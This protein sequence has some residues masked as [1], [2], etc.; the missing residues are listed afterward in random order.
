[1]GRGLATDGTIARN[2]INPNVELAQQIAEFY[3]NPLDHVLF[4]YPWNRGSLAGFHGPDDWARGYLVELGQEVKERAFDGHNAVRPIRFSTASGHGIGKSALVAWLIRWLMDTRPV[5]KGVVTANT[6]AQLRSKTWAEL[7]KWHTLGI[8][9]HWYTLTGGTLGSLSYY[10]TADPQTWRFDAQTCEERN[11]EAFAGQHAAGSTSAYIFDEAGGI[12]DKIFEVREGGLTDGEPHVHDFGNPTRNTGRFFENMQGRFREMYRRRFIDSRDVA[13]TNKETIEEWRLNYGEDSDFFKVRVKGVFPDS[14]S[15]Q[16]MSRGDVESCVDLDVHVDPTDALVLGVDVARFGDDES[17]IW[18]KRGRDCEGGGY[19]RYAG[20]DT[21]QL[22]ARINDLANKLRPDAI[23]I[24]GGGVGGGVVDR[25]RQ[26]NLDVTEVNF[27]SKATQ[28]GYA[29]LR[30]QMWGNLREAIK[31]G[32]RLP[33]DADLISDLTGVEYGFTNSN[34]IQLEKK[35]D[36]K[37]RGLKSPDLADA[38]A[39]CFVWPVFPSRMGWHNSMSDQQA[40]SD[41]NPYA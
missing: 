41:Y 7:S 27:G 19:F 17:V 5:M 40:Q 37:K 25:C 22:A 3:A 21:M 4:S 6:A 30:A 1:M 36:M 12:P 28:P 16:F 14:G 8:T 35:E 32:V 24:D 29:N 23:F 20:L 10:R 39:L 9:R 13:I 38:L 2:L 33:D 26:L 18:I 31:E 15:T 11:S 34:L